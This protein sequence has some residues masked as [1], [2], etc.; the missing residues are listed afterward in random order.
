MPAPAVAATSGATPTI[1]IVDVERAW[2]RTPLEGHRVL[3]I[4]PSS[5][6]AVQ[7]VA[8]N[9]T[10]VVVNIAL[11]GGL[12]RERFASGVHPSSALSVFGQDRII[13]IG[14][15]KRSRGRCRRRARRYG[16]ARI[17]AGA[18]VF[19]GRDA[20]ALM[21]M[22]QTLAKRGFRCRWRATWQIDKLPRWCDRR[23]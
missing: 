16:R 5:D 9:P 1:V 8:A 19:A 11:P 10:R 4:A 17:A 15:S 18:R 2:E 3:V 21:K 20:E 14:V 7:V 12:A 23:S 22:R 6:A 13:G